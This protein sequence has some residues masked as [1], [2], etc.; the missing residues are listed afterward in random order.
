MPV[1]SWTANKMWVF[2]LCLLG[3]SILGSACPS[4][5]QTQHAIVC[6]IGGHVQSGVDQLCGQCWGAW[7]WSAVSEMILAYYESRSLEGVWIVLMNSMDEWYP[8]SFFV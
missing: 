3:W 6:G 7:V 2:P 4:A 5:L 8:R 1:L